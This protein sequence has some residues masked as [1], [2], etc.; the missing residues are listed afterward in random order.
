V[1]VAVDELE[2]KDDDAVLEDR[3]VELVAE[4]VTVAV[5]FPFG[6]VP[7]AFVVIGTVTL[8]VVPMSGEGEVVGAPERGVIGVRETID[9]VAFEA[10]PKEA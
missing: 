8:V 2:L 3:V 7:T 4:F 5:L 1:C 6:G 9:E 10:A